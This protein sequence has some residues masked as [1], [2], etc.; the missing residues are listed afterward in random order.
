MVLLAKFRVK[1]FWSTRSYIFVLRWEIFLP[2][3]EFANNDKC[4]ESP[5]E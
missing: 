5:Q 2:I 4:S 3:Y 1:D